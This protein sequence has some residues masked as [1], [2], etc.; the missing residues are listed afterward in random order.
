MVLLI[1]SS[2]DIDNMWFK[3]THGQFEYY[4]FLEKMI[5]TLRTII[6]YFLK[7]MENY[8]LIDP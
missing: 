2:G 3:D 4:I 5:F 7:R 6:K 1:V 8:F